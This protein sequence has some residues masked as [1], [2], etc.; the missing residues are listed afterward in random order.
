MTVKLSFNVNNAAG[1]RFNCVVFT[2]TVADQAT[3]MP[4][5]LEA[6]ERWRRCPFSVPVRS[7]C[8]TF[9]RST[10]SGYGIRET[11]KFRD[12]TTKIYRFRRTFTP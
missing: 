9:I 7:A 1:R 4:F 11:I 8:L 3:V 2:D 6:E 12:G 10:G 5:I